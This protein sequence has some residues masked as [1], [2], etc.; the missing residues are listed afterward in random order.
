MVILSVIALCSLILLYYLYRF[1][2]KRS[3]QNAAEVD[4]RKENG[5]VKGYRKDKNGSWVYDET[6]YL[7]DGHDF[8]HDHDFER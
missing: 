5:K 8:N 6:L 4:F 3:D 1:I 7:E 2:K